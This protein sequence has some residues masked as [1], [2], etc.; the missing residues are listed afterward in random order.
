MG[1]TFRYNLDAKRNLNF[2]DNQKGYNN[3]AST[4]DSSENKTRDIEAKAL[5]SIFSGSEFDNILEIGC[6][7]GKNTE[8]LIKRAKHITGVDFSEGMIAKAKNKIKADNVTFNLFDIREK[9]EFE[10]EHFDLIICSLVLEHIDNLEFVF[11]QANKK[12]AKGGLLYI[13]ELHPYKQYAGSKARFDTSEGTIVLECFLHNISD[14]YNSAK[15]NN[16]NCINFKEWFDNDDIQT[17]PRLLSMVFK[18]S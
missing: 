15:N 1:K 11:E 16:L 17:I 4:Y 12:L 2:M 3:W 8:W 6:G 7:T 13:G 9:W 10:D 14:F 18:K 5:R